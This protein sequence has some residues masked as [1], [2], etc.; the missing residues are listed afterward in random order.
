MLSL[1][2]KFVM[3]AN[4]TQA[5]VTPVVLGRWGIH[6]DPKVIDC[7]VFQANEDHCGCCVDVAVEKGRSEDLEKRIRYEKGEEYLLPYIV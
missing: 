3:G 4:A 5:T 2:R 6:Y 7:K 1:I